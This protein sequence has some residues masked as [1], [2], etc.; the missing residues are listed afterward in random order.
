M[1]HIITLNAG[2]SSLKFALFTA[3]GPEPALI[4]SGAVERIG[5]P[6]ANL[7]ARMADGEVIADATPGALQDHAGAIDCVLNLL[8][9]HFP[10]ARV[11]SVGHRIVHGGPDHDRP[12]LLA[13]DNLNTLEMLEPFAPLHQ[14]FNLQGVRAAMARFPQAQQV[15][16]FDTAFH[17]HHPWVNDTFALP[18]EYY[19]MGVRRYG[20]HGLSYDYISGHLAETAPQVH[21]GRVVVAH[22]GNGASMCGMKN[23]ES[24][25]SSMGFSAMD[26][27]PMG[28]RSGQIDPGALLFLMQQKGMGA[29]EIS[30]LLYRQSGLLGMS[31][32]SNDMRTLEQSDRPEARRAIEYFTFRARRELGALTAV[33]GG[34]D[35]VVF[36]GGIGEHSALVRQQICTDMGWFGIDLNPDANGD[37]ARVISTD[38]SRVQVMVI[39]TN[40]ELV[41]ARAALGFLI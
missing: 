22:L 4:C 27:L 31:G 7:C 34:L 41:I 11:V 29:A 17:R 9:G 32:L 35:A 18:I 33:L 40:E 2:S 15:A 21:A 28:T 8:A 39:P 20:F 16:C 30:D 5:R 3:E 1:D 14:P 13:P 10:S 25:G 19:E 37:N 6:A 26:G 38:T 36:T 12:I 23:G 24:I